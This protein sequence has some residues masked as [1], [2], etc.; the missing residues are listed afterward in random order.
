MAASSACDVERRQSGLE[1][2]AVRLDAAVVLGADADVDVE[3]V[4]LGELVQVA[5]AVGDQP[6][7]KTVR[8]QRS[9]R[10]QRVV[11][12][13]EV[14]VA[15]PLAHDLHR[16][17][18]SALRRATHAAHDRLGERDPDLLVVLELG[19]ALEARQ[20]REAR[21]LVPVGIERQ[22]VTLTCSAIPLRPELRPRLEEREVDVEEHRAQ[23]RG[24]EGSARGRRAVAIVAAACG[25]CRR[26]D[27]P[28]PAI[29]AAVPFLPL[30][31]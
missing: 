28:R 15:L 23:H 8:P 27:E 4:V 14:L 29:A 30:G 21:V 1:D 7:A 10:G 3:L 25:D 16:A 13:E 19:M 17:R 26:P 22:P 5:L 12:E 24:R 9:D 6:D 2:G 31:V 11:V 18:A 20:R